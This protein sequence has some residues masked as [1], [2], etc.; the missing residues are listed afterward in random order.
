M[1]DIYTFKREYDFE[2]IGV[3]GTVTNSIECDDWIQLADEFLEFLQGCGFVV[4]RERLAEHYTDW[5]SDK[6]TDD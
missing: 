1:T 2:Y 4:D 5:D 3:R 6:E